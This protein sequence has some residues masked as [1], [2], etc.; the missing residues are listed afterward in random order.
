MPRELC[1]ICQEWSHAMESLKGPQKRMDFM[2]AH[3]PA[4]LKNTALFAELIH[5]VARG[6]TYP[7]VRHTDAF[8]NEI[9][10]YLNPRRIFSIRMFLFGPGEF[11]PVHDHNAWGI[12]GS[13]INTLTIVRYSRDDD[14]S[15]DGHAR[16]HETGRETFLPGEIETTLPLDAG[17]HKA[18]NATQEPMVMVS[19]Y[20]TPIRRL[21]V[22]GYDVENNRVY[23]MYPPRMK[24]RLL[25]KQ[26]LDRL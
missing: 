9:L 6:G 4:L 18:G 23:R 26:T 14:G 3:V 7:D 21:Y 25:A 20:G 13:V 5:R 22:N 10:L 1:G 19:V 12:T 8:D 15:V 11:N 24:K 17:I 16:I 2:Q